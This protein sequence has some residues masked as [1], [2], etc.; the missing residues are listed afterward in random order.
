MIQFIVLAHLHMN[1]LQAFAFLV[2][3]NKHVR[4]IEMQ[5][6]IIYDECIIIRVVEIV[7][8]DAIAV[9]KK[10]SQLVKSSAV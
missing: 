3:V 4:I 8:L 7:N 6:F 2:M 9:I 5:I 1:I 10:I